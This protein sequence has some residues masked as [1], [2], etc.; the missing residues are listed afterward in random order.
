[1]MSPAAALPIESAIAPLL[2]AL[3]A[4]PCVV[5]SAAP[6]AGK[7]TRVPL[8]LLE[9]GLFKGRILMLEPRRLAAVGAAQFMARQ[10]GE[11]VGARVGY[12]IRGDSRISAG[13]RIE[14]VTEGILTRLLQAD[15]ALAGVDLVIFDEFHERSIHADLGLAFTRDVQKNLRDD[16]KI[17]VMS[18]TLDGVAVSRLL[19]DAPVVESKGRQF[20]VSLHYQPRSPSLSLE[21]DVAQLVQR[22]L[23]EQSKGDV[24]VFL[25]GQGEI[26][27]CQQQLHQQLLDDQLVI[28][29]LFGESAAAQ[30]QAA[31]AAD[32]AGRRKIIL[33]T[34]IAETSLTIDGV[35]VVV[36]AGL[37]RTARFDPRRAMSGLVTLPVSQATAEQRAGR[38][39]RQ[40]AGACYRLWSES[41]H[42][43]LAPYPQAE[44]LQSDLLPLA[45]DLLRWGSDVQQLAF[46]DP[47]PAALLAQAQ[48]VL[49]QLGAMDQQHKITP[50]GRAMAELPVHPRI[51][52]MLVRANE[53][54]LGAIACDVAALLE[55]RDLLR[56][57]NER[58]VDFYSRWQ[59]LSTAGPGAFSEGVDRSTRE[60]VRQQARR[61]RQMLSIKDA[62]STS[63]EKIGLMLAL[64]YPE[65]VARRRDERG[66]RWL[67]ASGRGASLPAA[68]PFARK[69]WIAVA[70]I[71]S[72]GRD[73][74][75]YLA[76]DLDEGDLPEFFPEWFFRGDEV[77]WSEQEGAVV[78]RRVQRFGAIIIS[79]QL[80]PTQA[81]AADVARVLC[82]TLRRKGWPALPLDTGG[83]AWLQRV[84]WLQGNHLLPANFPDFS[85]EA[86]LLQLDDWLLP[87]LTGIKQ[88][89]Q[90]ERIDWRNALQARLDYSQLKLV[91]QLAP[92]HI[93]VPTGSSVALDYAG[94]QPV[95][96]VRLQEMFGERDTPRIANQQVPV[97]LHLLSPKRSPLAVT[98]DLSSFWQNAYKEVCK[99]M[100]GQY[101]K[102]YWPDNPLEAAPTRRTKAA[103]DRARK[104]SS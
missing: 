85:A 104:R 100:R 27:R 6:G 5:L 62:A 23:K 17:L 88:L 69:Q 45:L 50:H 76:A 30:Q 63:E 58:N 9:A 77:F 70:D 1:M 89:S 25:P 20:P 41:Q 15:P 67:L 33:S 101:P 26:R 99:D 38:A 73:S 55:D 98:Q 94:P 79:E 57:G 72:E 93:T 90:L 54:Q 83:K 91:D 59:A 10:L 65:R 31:L 18:A 71:N 87:Y 95:L 97:L 86:L 102:H 21:A 82:D 12:R 81:A 14:V 32:P 84:Q 35:A 43:R 22:A 7:T 40:Q 2:Q 78:S 4:S 66:E 36:D 42:L 51:A 56:Q 61:L 53:H 80:L 68:N 8:A 52:H 11:D 19:D 64:C 49:R 16:L 92:T 3:S 34:S 44:I 46:L 48:E 60:R 74:R 39:G 37:V 47:P 29:S 28:H 96:A 75:I 24:L 13:T 103:D